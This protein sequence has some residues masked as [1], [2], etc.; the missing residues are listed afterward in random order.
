[1]VLGAADMSL[2]SA[3]ITGFREGEVRNV[4]GIPANVPVVTLLAVGYPDGF[5][6]LPGRRP[7]AESIAWDRWD[8]TDGGRGH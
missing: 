4:L 1:M 8:A 3:W 2:A 7:E 5:Q 6:R